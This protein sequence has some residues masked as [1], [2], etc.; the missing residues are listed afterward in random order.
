MKSSNKAK[1]VVPYES[2]TIQE[3]STPQLKNALWSVFI[4]FTKGRKV[5]LLV[6]ARKNSI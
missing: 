5:Q 3:V 6:L 4:P 1:L 2:K